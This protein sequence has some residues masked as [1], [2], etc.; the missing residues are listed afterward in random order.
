MGSILSWKTDEI[1]TL[2]DTS[3]CQEYRVAEILTYN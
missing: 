1:F 2:D 3:Y